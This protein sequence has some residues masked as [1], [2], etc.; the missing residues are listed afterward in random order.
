[1]TRLDPR[2]LV[3][4]PLLLTAAAPPPA[5]V[6]PPGNVTTTY[7]GVTVADPYRALENGTNPQVIAWSEAENDRAHAYLDEVPGR[8]ELASALRAMV[9]ATS[10]AYDTLQAA[11]PFVFA[12][13]HDPKFQQT[14]LVRMDA[15]AN[16]ATRAMVLDPNTL[17]KS[18]HTEIDWY[19]AS[20]DGRKVAVSLSRDGSEDGTLHVYDVTTGAEI[21][22]PIANVQYPTAGG[23]LA[24]LPDGSAFWYTRYPGASMP[25]ADQ[26]FYQAV[27]LHK[28]GT[29]A[30]A[31]PEILGKAQSL[32]RTGEIFLDNRD[33]A[34][35][36]LAAVQLG[37][38]GQWQ[39]YLLRPGQPALKLADYA[40]QIDAVALAHDGTVYGVSRRNAPMGRVLKLAPPYTGGIAAGKIFVP[41]NPSVAIVAGGEFS[42]PLTPLGGHLLVLGVA[43]GPNVLAD[44]AANGTARQVKLPD[45]ASV[46]EVDAM[47]RGEAL[48]Q[49]ATYTRP[50]EFQ[51]YAT[52]T[53]QS[54]PTDLRETS[55]IA[56]ADAKV[57]RAFARSKDGTMIPMTIIA[58]DSLRNDGTNPTLMY[59]YGG[60]GI[61]T[62]PGFL[63]PIARLWL[64]AGGVYVLTNIRG[65][66]EYG[67]TWHQQGM[68]TRKQNVFDDFD[69]CGQYL[70]A[71]HITDHA[72]LALLGGSNG[73]LLMGAMITQ[74]PHLAHAVV[75]LVGIYDMLRLE[76]DANGAFNVTE[77]GTVNNAADFKALYAYSPYY[78]VVKATDYPAVL[79][80]TGA[81]DGRVNPMQS[82][83]FTAALQA[84]NASSNPILLTV[85]QTSGHGI[86]SSLD[87][88]IGQ[89]VDYL[90]FL[91]QELGMS[92]ERA[93]RGS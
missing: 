2:L 66:G 48:Y 39:D 89:Q 80:M 37:D 81:H 56:F 46:T 68:L 24:W 67:T 30:A 19:A 73:G 83:K 52:R 72:H 82:R 34:N 15:T 38:G 45:V 55:P 69:A 18:G 36:A 64:N 71:H 17:D 75:S 47:P 16:P 78:H 61:S 62:S 31:D 74:H 4:L 90:A 20:P 54:T 84:A 86:G 40:D 70:I 57:T 44:Y 43:G 27:Y 22:A 8:S 60:F 9:T 91:F 85:S 93:A 87:D 58:P 26:H 50:P 35:A 41:E 63:G 77:Y 3:A 28:L 25:P 51:R 88:R 32:P 1:M 53:G 14:M 49:V 59:G 79:M 5:S 13:Y 23:S 92:A 11:G 6:F 12:R 21:G 42:Q 7:H 76:Q 33:G 29:D 10:P 65:G